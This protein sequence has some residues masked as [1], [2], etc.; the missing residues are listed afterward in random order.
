MDSVIIRSWALL[1]QRRICHQYC[2]PHFCSCILCAF[3]SIHAFNAYYRIVEWFGLKRTL[4]IFQF[5]LPCHGQ[6]Y[7]PL[8]QAIDQ[9]VQGSNSSS[10]LDITQSL[11]PTYLNWL[12]ACNRL[13]QNLNKLSMVILGQAVDLTQPEETDHSSWQLNVNMYNR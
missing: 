1:C 10:R 13:Q 7:H 6:S 2:S 11:W 3:S 8:N 5:Q 12:R 9:I 4:Q